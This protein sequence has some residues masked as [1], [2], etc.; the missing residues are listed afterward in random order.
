MTSGRE[1]KKCPKTCT[2][3]DPNFI[4]SAFYVIVLSLRDM[5]GIVM[6]NSVSN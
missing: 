5:S 2:L 4:T 1:R 3:G 6:V